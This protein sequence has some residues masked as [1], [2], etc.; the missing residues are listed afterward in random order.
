MVGSIRKF[1]KKL[2]ALTE[3]IIQRA[4]ISPDLD[5]LSIFVRTL[6]SL[7]IDLVGSEDFTKY[8]KQSLQSSKSR[9]VA[10]TATQ[11]PQVSFKTLSGNEK[12]RL[13]KAPSNSTL[14]FSSV[15]QKE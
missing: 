4:T 10:L 9:N 1:T 3:K 12:R 7:L 8:A 2:C 5:T 11:T 14:R 15:S 13:F 6:N